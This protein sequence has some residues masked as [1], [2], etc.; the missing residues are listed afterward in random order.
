MVTELE[1]TPGQLAELKLLVPKVSTLINE[2]QRN[3]LWNPYMQ[4]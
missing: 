3:D 2:F 4:R 1:A